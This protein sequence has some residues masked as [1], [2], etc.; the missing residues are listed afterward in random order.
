MK[1]IPDNFVQSNQ[2]M[3][4]PP[5]LLAVSG[6]VLLIIVASAMFLFWGGTPNTL[7]LSGNSAGQ[8]TDVHT[9]VQ[10]SATGASAVSPTGTG[11]RTSATGTVAQPSTNATATPS[12]SEKQKLLD[13]MQQKVQ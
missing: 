6:V 4:I 5:R 2:E 1:L 8:Q 9:P 13:A 11:A 10:S 3:R 7:P 12:P